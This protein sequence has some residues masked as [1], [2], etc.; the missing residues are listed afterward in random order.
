[1]PKPLLRYFLIPWVVVLI[2]ARYFTA[3]ILKAD[4]DTIWYVD[5][6]STKLLVMVCI[7]CLTH[8]DKAFY[9]VLVVVFFITLYQTID[10]LT[11]DM[12]SILHLVGYNG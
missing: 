3:F 4:V 6:L 11:T 8:K 12:K 2:S 1:M 10:I 9:V 7:V 5:A